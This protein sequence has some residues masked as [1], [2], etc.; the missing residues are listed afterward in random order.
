MNDEESEIEM[1]L[2]EKLRIVNEIKK[3][4]NQI[5]ISDRVSQF[6]KKFDKRR[7][8]NLGL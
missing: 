1:E 4:E 8:S 6:M 3:I 2:N 5:L 7:N